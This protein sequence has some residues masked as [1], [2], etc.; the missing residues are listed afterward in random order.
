MPVLGSTAYPTA[1]GVMQVVRAL[2]NDANI[3]ANLPIFISSVTRAA[4]VVTVNTIGPHG[5]I[6]GASPDQATIAGVPVGANSFNGTFSVASVINA[7]QFTYAQ[8]GANETA[9]GAGSV[10]NVGQGAVWTDGVLLPYVNV[11]YRKVADAL[12]NVGAP[13]PVRDDV[14]LVIPAIGTAPDASVQVSLTDSTTPQLPIDLEV[15]MKLWERP[16][17]SS[18][19]F[20][21]MVDMTNKGGLP[22]RFQTQVLSVWE[23]RTDG[24]YFLGATQDTQIRMRYRAIYAD[25]VDGTSAVLIRKST[26]AIAFGAAALAGA[27]RGSPL[28]EKWDAGAVDAMEDLVARAA[29]QN[30]RVGTRRRPF[31]SRSGWSPF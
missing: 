14:L 17:G 2:L 29:R 3:G 26:N 13:S 7:F 24:I 28:A 5:L 11:A 23:W 6:A 19:E 1:R 8:A 31:S 15:P 27:S 12:E 21:E 22:S 10:A 20:M 30:Q 16:N 9:N 25:L 4:S 18:Q